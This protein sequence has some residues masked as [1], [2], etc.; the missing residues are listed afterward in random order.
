MTLLSY[1]GDGMSSICSVWHF[2]GRTCLWFRRTYVT[3]GWSTRH[4]QWTSRPFPCLLK[5]YSS[6]KVYSQTGML[7]NNVIVLGC[8]WV[9]ACSRFVKS[10]T[11]TLLV[12]GYYSYRPIVCCTDRYSVQS[13]HMYMYKQASYI[14]ANWKTSVR[15]C[16]S[17]GGN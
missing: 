13:K 2:S 17:S 3:Q 11:Q 8:A 9:K 6:I 15:P 1:F 4:A 12:I 10:T 16:M 5:T 14:F 7:D